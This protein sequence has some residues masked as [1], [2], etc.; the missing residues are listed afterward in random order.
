VITAAFLADIH[1]AMTTLQDIPM[2]PSI[3]HLT[4]EASTRF[5]KIDV[6]ETT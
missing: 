6:L 3:A 2:M 1:E 5:P 4:P